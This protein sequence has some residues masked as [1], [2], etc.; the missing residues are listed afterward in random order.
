MV[1]ELTT[2]EPPGKWIKKSESNPPKSPFCKGGGVQK[3]K[4]FPPHLSS[5][6]RGEELYKGR[7]RVPVSPPGGLAAPQGKDERERWSW[8][9]GFCMKGRGKFHPH[10]CPLPSRERV[11]FL[12][13]MRLDCHGTCA[14]LNDNR[15]LFTIFSP[16][17][18][19]FFHPLK[20]PSLWPGPCRCSRA[21]CRRP[22]PCRAA[23]RR[24]RPRWGR[25]P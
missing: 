9:I 3:E 19:L 18:L 6:A 5:P 16:S 13:G 23:R 10:P 12:R 4:E 25:S 2:K 7:G 17:W 20:G 1:D 24:C 11:H 15:V 14:P 8:G 22:G 21:G